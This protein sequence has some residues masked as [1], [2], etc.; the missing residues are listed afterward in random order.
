MTA[1]VSR[2]EFGLLRLLRGLLDGGPVEPLATLIY[3]D[4]GAQPCLSR[5]CVRLVEDTL[6]KGVI[7]R[8]VRAGGWRAERFLRADGPATGR[9]WERVP[10][11]DR[12][13]SFGPVS[14]RFLMWL[15]ASKPTGPQADGWDAQ[16]HEMTAG[17]EVFLALAFDALKPLLDVTPTLAAKQAV[18][19]NR[20]AWL[21]GP[22]EFTTLAA[23]TPPAF[24]GW[25]A[26]VR[27][28][29]LECLQPLL[30]E[31]WTATE[32][33]KAQ[34]SDWG[35]LRRQGEAEAATLAG[36]LTA[37]E[38]AGRPD[39][40]RFLLRTVQVVL[41]AGEVSPDRWTAGL[42]GGGP[43]RLADRLATRRAAM[44][45]PAQVA[46]L[47]RWDRQ[48]RAVGYFDDGYE[49]SQV[50]KADWEAADGDALAARAAALLA[51]V[52]PLT[53]G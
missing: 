36:F 46:T 38:G 22:G 34:V 8:L 31:R 27:A 29:V 44:A 28:C 9:A 48:A 26:G 40:A 14:V 30:A 21:L 20:L 35:R 19:H 13:L 4:P 11:A 51:A 49:S 33:A 15:T 2:F 24:D 23:A 25:T 18:R 53:T 10:L 12:R 3:A 50:W 52:E 42:Q 17:D 1:T 39:L 45:V 5:T 47:Q 16:P 41:P 7:G 43:K 6:A 37:C 32:R